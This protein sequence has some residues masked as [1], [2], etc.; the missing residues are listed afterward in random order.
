MKKLVNLIFAVVVSIIFL[1]S[2]VWGT[3]KSHVNRFLSGKWQV[4]SHDT[5]ITIYENGVFYMN[6]TV[7]GSYIV[8]PML[9]DEMRFIWQDAPED[10]HG[11][12]WKIESDGL[13]GNLRFIGFVNDCEHVKVYGVPY[14]G[15]D[16][17]LILKRIVDI[18]NIY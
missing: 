11:L 14:F 6:D 15:K 5:T 7:E 10:I 18:E 17:I 1:N 12:I 9:D 16:S 2:C 13:K 3:S 8:E 4:G